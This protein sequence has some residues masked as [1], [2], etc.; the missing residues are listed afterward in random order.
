[1]IGPVGSGKSTVAGEIAAHLGLPIIDLDEI[2]WRSGSA[3]TEEAWRQL[4]DV[5]L[6]GPKW[7]IAGDYRATAR[8]RFTAA[9]T[10][11]WL[12]LP[13]ALCAMRAIRRHLLGHPAPLSSCLRW[14]GRYPHVGSKETEAALA[15]TSCVEIHRFRS[16]RQV[17][18]FLHAVRTSVGR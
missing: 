15:A 11:I 1:M 7:V 14:I 3:P 8:A 6:T 17:T 13:V 9:D 16:R 5:L 2:Y 10:V 12:D 18:T 4:H